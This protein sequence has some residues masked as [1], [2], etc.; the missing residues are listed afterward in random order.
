MTHDAAM[1]TMRRMSAQSSRDAKTLLLLAQRAVDTAPD[2]DARDQAKRWR[3]VYRA[4]RLVKTTSFPMKLLSWSGVDIR[5]VDAVEDVFKE[6][7][8]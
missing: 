3:D 1:L 6:M 5:L 8:R 4:G 7:E 2:D